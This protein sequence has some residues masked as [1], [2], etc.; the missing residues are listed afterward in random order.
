MAQIV[1]ITHLFPHHDI[2]L[3]I[4]LKWYLNPWL[5]PIIWRFT[6][7]YSTLFDNQFMPKWKKPIRCNWQFATILIDYSQVV[8]TSM[9]LLYPI[10]GFCNI[11]LILS[12][13][14]LTLMSNIN[15]YGVQN[16][17]DSLITSMNVLI[18]CMPIGKTLFIYSLGLASK[19]Q[20]VNGS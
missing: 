14:I 18:Y 3:P 9:G 11:K 15:W 1:D 6:I 13:H 20:H 5:L 4:P 19:N 8:L 7:T 17:S 10:D 12:Y 16:D 2:F